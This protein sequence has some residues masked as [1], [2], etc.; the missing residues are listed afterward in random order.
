MT[1]PIKRSFNE[2]LDRR[3]RTPDTADA[4]MKLAAWCDEKGLKDQAIAHYTA[5]TRFDPSRDAAWKHLGYKKQGS[6]WVKPE[7]VA[8]AKQ[9]AVRQKQADKAL[10]DEARKV[11]RW[12]GE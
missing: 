8:A 4:Q 5:V 1:R 12:A 2:Y 6:R 11:A 7:E 9:E 3:A 10:E